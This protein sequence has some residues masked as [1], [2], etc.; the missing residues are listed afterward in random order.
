[1][2]SLSFSPD[3]SKLA[4][5][6]REAT[7]EIWDLN[8]DTALI[9]YQSKEVLSVAFSPDG[10]TLASGG[11]DSAVRLWDASLNSPALKLDGHKTNVSSVS[12]DETKNIFATAGGDSSIKLWDLRTG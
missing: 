11:W 5:A 6:N 7:V 10:D 8:T 3:G 2:N 9:L 4:T 1:M 12:V